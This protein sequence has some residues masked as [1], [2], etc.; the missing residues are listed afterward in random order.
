MIRTDMCHLYMVFKIQNFRIQEIVLSI[1]G[2]KEMTLS[3]T[4]NA[5]DEREEKKNQNFEYLIKSI[6]NKK[7]LTLSLG[8]KTLDIFSAKFLSRTALM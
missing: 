4:W 1:I 5:E 7:N 8:Y 6:H 2:K 3:I